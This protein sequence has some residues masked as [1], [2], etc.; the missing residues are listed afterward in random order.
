[1]I[2]EIESYSPFDKQAEFHSSRA[3]YRLFGGAAGPGKSRALL[4]EACAWALKYPGVNTLLLR[5]TYPELESS[6]IGPFRQHILPPWIGVQGFRFS[7]S[8]HTVH[9]P[10]SS[11]TQ[12]GYCADVTSER[13][14]LRYQGGEYLWIGLDEL[15]MFP[16]FVWKFL[17]SRNRCPV[18]GTR[19]RMAGASNPGGI[20]HDWVKKLFIDKVPASEMDELERRNYDPNDYA[21][22][23]ARLEHNPIYA[24]DAEY[25]KTLEALPLHMRR[26]FLEGDWEKFKGQYF[27]DWSEEATYLDHD[28]FLHMWGPQYWHPIWI[29]IDWGSTHH[30]Y[31]A[32]HTFL[33]IAE[34]Q[35]SL[36]EPVPAITR[37]DRQ[38]LIRAEAESRQRGAIVRT[39]DVPVTFR[40]Y[41]VSGLGEEA[42]AEEIVRRT[43]DSERRRVSH[44]FLSPDTGFQSELQRGWRIG[45]V[46]ARHNMPRARAAFDDRIDGWRLMHDKLRDRVIS[47]GVQFAGWCM[48]SNCP[49]ALEAIPLAVADPDKDGDI[50]AEG[51][52]PVLDVLDGLRYGV[53]SYE[54]A[55]NEPTSERKKQAIAQSP[56]V[57]RF[58]AEKMFDA[59]EKQSQPG[60]YYTGGWKPTQK[61]RQH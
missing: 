50:L 13:D 59:E 47:R 6:L 33:T 25:R 30:A 11:I 53:A 4:E 56:P 36:P 18:A 48:T 17:S 9:W 57:T 2:T 40:E 37:E 3:K 20:G 21:F 51:D 38:R 52:S 10:N 22:I 34:D 26:A 23:A 31:A 32:W 39:R 41:L 28:E 5:R 45:S 1:M 12:F 42:L 8:D 46:F 58:M 60:A 24:N 14:V 55:V 49:R 19:P 43:P 54:R 16:Y 29:S 44:V 7:Q 61:R 35:P 15:T 27:G